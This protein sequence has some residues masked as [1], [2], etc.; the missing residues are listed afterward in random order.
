MSSPASGEARGSVRLLLT[1]NHRVPTPA[2]YQRWGPSFFF[3]SVCHPMTSPALHEARGSVRLLLTKNH[4]VPTSALRAKAAI[5]PLRSPQLRIRHCPYW[6]SSVEIDCPVAGQLTQRAQRVAGSIPVRSNSLC[7]P[8]IRC[9]MLCCCGCVWLPPIIFIG[10]RVKS[11]NDCS[12]LGRGSVRFSLTINHPVPT[13]A[14][15]AGAPINPL[16]SPQLRIRHQSCWA[17]SVVIHKMRSETNEVSID[18]GKKNGVNGGPVAHEYLDYEPSG[19]LETTLLRVGSSTDDFIKQNRSVMKTVTLFALNGL[20]IGFF[21]GSLYHYLTYVN[22]P[23]ELCHGFGSLIAFL[24]II[25]FFIIYF[26]VVKRLIGAW[27]ERTVWDRVAKVFSKLWTMIYSLLNMVPH[28]RI[29]SCIVG[30]DTNIQVHMHITLRPETT[31]CGS[32]KELL[33]FVFSAHPGRINWRTVS[34]GLLIQFIFGVLFIRIF[35]CVVGAFTNIQIHIHMTPRPG[36]TIC[37]SHKTVA[38]FLSYGVEGAAFAFG[39]L[40]VRTEGVFAFSTLP[41]IFFFS[42]LVEILFFWGAL[43]WFVL[44]LGQVLRAATGTTVCEST[45]SILLIKPYLALQTPSELHVVMASGFATVSGTILASYIG[46]GA[47]PAHLV[48]ASVM[49]APA[50]VCYAKLLLPETKR[51][52]TT[53]D[54]IQPV[55]VEDKSVLS[56][57]TRGATNGIA[58]VLNIIANIIA[59]VAFVAFVNG[60]LGYCGNLIGSENFTLEWIF[61]KVFIPLAWPRAEL[62]ATYSLCGFT[63]PGSAG[64]MIGA[65]AAM[66][67]GQREVLSIMIP[68]RNCEVFASVIFFFVIKIFCSLAIWYRGMYRKQ[69]TLTSIPERNENEDE[70]LTSKWVPKKKHEVLKAKYKCLKK[71]FQIYDASVIGILPESYG[72]EGYL[73]EDIKSTKKRKKRSHRTKTDACA[74]TNEVSS[75]DVTMHTDT[76]KESIATSVIRDL[77]I[78]KCSCTSTQMESIQ[79]KDSKYAAT[80]ESKENMTLERAITIPNIPER[81][82]LERHE[83]LERLDCQ[84]CEFTQTSDPHPHP[85]PHPIPY[86]MMSEKRK[87]TR[88]QCFIHRIFGIRQERPYK[89]YVLPNGHVYAAS[90]NNISHNFCDKRRRRGLRF[91]RLRRPKKIQSE[92]ALRDVKSPFILTYVQSVQRNCLMD[93]TPR[94]INYNDHLNLCHFTDRKYIC[95]YCHEG[96]EREYDKYIHENE[97]IGI[98][99]LGDIGISKLGDIAISKLAS[100][101]ISTPSA[102]RLTFKKASNTQTDPEMTKCDVP[103]DKL[104]KIVSFF[105]KISDPDQILTEIKK[106]R[107]SESNLQQSKTATLETTEESDSSDKRTVSCVNLHRKMV[108]SKSASSADTEVTSKLQYSSPVACHI[109]GEHFNYRRQLSLHVDLEHRVHDKFSKFHSCAGILNRRSLNRVDMVSEDGKIQVQSLDR[110]HSGV[111]RSNSEVSQDTYSEV[112]HRRSEESLSCDPSTNIVYY[113]SRETVKKPSVVN[114]F[115][116]KVRSGFNSYKWEP[117]TKIIQTHTTA[118]TDPHR[119]D[120][121]FGNAYIRCV[122]MTSYGMRAMRTMRAYLHLFTYKYHWVYDALFYS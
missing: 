62:I 88:F 68:Y 99:K 85:L 55:E 47:E 105:D 102:T 35:S 37:G 93:T 64:I 7:D 96:F 1:K 106:S 17:P 13:P 90:D 82:C 38:T 100:A 2:F 26:V 73:E 12:R 21:F 97:H 118:S 23:L 71:L 70:H 114:S 76:D 19:W 81:D 110:T 65:I 108:K 61:G 32:H 31:I 29:F 41:V 59:F 122:L 115:V 67:P 8:Q 77:K 51:S 112:S 25:Y 121:I 109:C 11:S 117:G 57:A 89:N 83:R 111:H 52:L 53:V 10:T 6:T 78:T 56:A 42:M 22:E 28:I 4:P 44:K 46:F 74:G 54:N 86:L 87:L 18:D 33:R 60:V 40:L 80:Q 94:I 45:E 116:K 103:E 101:N 119:T 27:F 79:P 69:P 3:L 34:T 58:L 113:T 39:D 14:F 50:A 9:A 72:P 84:E 5:K 98:S 15:R 104:K 20:V 63:N 107:F 16:G 43:Q 91:R 30:A 95:H 24:G 120:R 49:S 92:I 48:T 75:G 36:T 66:A